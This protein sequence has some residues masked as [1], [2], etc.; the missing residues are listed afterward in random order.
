M[1]TLLRI[2]LALLPWCALAWLLAAENRESKRAGDA[3]MVVMLM[4]PAAIVVFLALRL[5]DPTA[6][7]LMGDDGILDMDI[8]RLVVTLTDFW[9]GQER[10]RVH[11]LMCLL[12]QP[13]G[14]LMSLTGLGPLR[15]SQAV[16]GLMLSLSVGLTA[17]AV[18]RYTGRRRPALLAGGLMLASFTFIILSAMPESAAIAAPTVILP[19]Y[20]YTVFKDRPPSRRE[21]ALFVLAGVLSLGVTTTNVMHA[22]IAYAL[23]RWHGERPLAGLRSAASYA[24]H[25]AA[26]T[27]LLA[28]AQQSLYP[29]SNLWFTPNS[30]KKE[31][32]FVQSKH[33]LSLS[34]ARDTATQ[35]F[36]YPLVGPSVRPTDG[37]VRKGVLLP[38]LSAEDIRFGELPALTRGLLLWIGA[39]LVMMLFRLRRLALGK[40]ILLALAANL[41]L[42]LIYGR[43][44]LLYSGNWLPVTVL[45]ISVAA[46]AG[47]ALGRWMWVPAVP[48]LIAGNWMSAARLA[49][50][51]GEYAPLFSTRSMIGYPGQ[52][53]SAQVYLNPFGSLSPGA[54]S[55]GIHFAIW[56]PGSRASNLP[57]LVSVRAE[58]GLLE[59]WIGVPVIASSAGGFRLEQSVFVSRKGRA[60]VRL[61]IGS[62]EEN[63]SGCA[64]VYVG[65]GS[66]GPGG[67][68]ERHGYEWDPGRRALISADRVVMWCEEAPTAVSMTSE[69]MVFT[70]A[71]EGRRSAP[72]AAHPVFRRVKH[73]SAA[74]IGLRQ[75]DLPPA[76][77]EAVLLC[78]E[79][80]LQPGECR[81]MWFDIPVQ[82]SDAGHSRAP[83]RPLMLAEMQAEAAEVRR[84]WMHARPVETSLPWSEW[85]I[86]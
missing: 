30:L 50:L 8:N 65:V 68:G 63:R 35:M 23:R 83:E 69:A 84:Y 52:P 38:Y 55:H 24:V 19:Y 25:V 62:G 86:P 49:D 9:H 53:T 70:A 66:Y 1:D 80:S 3:R 6:L 51:I 16:C 47:G 37:L 26:I 28:V 4:I 58:R 13:L 56:D 14:Y 76:S 39:A 78:W 15:A 73:Q 74:M 82:G 48:L 32:Y 61:D 33:A 79:V 85:D 75:G 67:S 64:L 43:D 2:A 44:Y 10:T 72:D 5:F 21:H 7:V 11:P 36:G 34:H 27:M 31:Q 46:W 29:G 22:L 45:G 42:H 54:R 59:G 20:L 77:A 60:L 41:A 12:F 40:A 17:A 57:E 71:L 81:E 18:R